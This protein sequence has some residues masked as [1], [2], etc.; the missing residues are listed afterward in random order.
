M[1]KNR[2]WRASW[3]E[4]TNQMVEDSK[5]IY[6]IIMYIYIYI[7]ICVFMC[8]YLD[9]LFH[10]ASLYMSKWYLSHFAS[11]LV[12]NICRNSRKETFAQH[13][14]PMIYGFS[15]QGTRGLPSDVPGLMRISRLLL[16]PCAETFRSKSTL[17]FLQGS[18]L[19]FEPVWV[20]PMIKRNF[21][22][23]CRCCTI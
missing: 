8:T 20:K 23:K 12:A 9:R 6:Y 17:V 4:F 3:I 19:G 16:G 13:I 21:R 5:R 11:S 1:F 2:I 10:S 7:H 15:S 18:P 14:G 22:I